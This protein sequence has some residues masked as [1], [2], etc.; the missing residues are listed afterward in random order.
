MSPG[1]DHQESRER[2][3]LKVLVENKVISEAQANLVKSD[4]EATAMSAEDILLARHWVSEET[5]KSLAP[6]LFESAK[7]NE[8]KKSAKTGAAGDSYKEN[9]KKYRALMAEILGESSE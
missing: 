6:W 1:P 4:Q 9:L 2:D 3:I 7:S 5:L 8:A